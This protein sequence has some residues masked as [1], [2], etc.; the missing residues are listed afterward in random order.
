MT[1]LYNI[2]TLDVGFVNQTI[3]NL[4]DFEASSI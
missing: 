1:K 3:M 2:Y 4:V